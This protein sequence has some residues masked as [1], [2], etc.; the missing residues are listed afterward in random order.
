MSKI[1]APSCFISTSNK[2]FIK[3]HLDKIILSFEQ[4]LFLKT[5][6]NLDDFPFTIA[7]IDEGKND[8]Q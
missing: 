4:K 6:K 7:L 3:I 5:E 1:I 2:P 8:L